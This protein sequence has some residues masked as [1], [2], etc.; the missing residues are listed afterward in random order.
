VVV[1]GERDVGEK[2][3][4][5]E[6]AVTRIE[7]GDGL[8]CDHGEASRGNEVSKGFGRVAELLLV[9]CE[10]LGRRLIGETAQPPPLL[11]LWTITLLSRVAPVVLSIGTMTRMC[12][13][14]KRRVKISE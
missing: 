6:M 11:L 3:R 8:I 14:C 7:G 1:R 2:T 9:R 10:V 13:R 4:I 5:D 12:Y